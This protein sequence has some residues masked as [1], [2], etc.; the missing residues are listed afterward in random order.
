MVAGRSIRILFILLTLIA[1]VSYAQ[2]SNITYPQED[3]SK[4]EEII[5]VCKTHFDIGYTHRVDELISFYRTAMIDK[6]LAIME[7]SEELPPEQQFV[8]TTPAWVMSKVL[9]DWDG[10]TPER[11]KK[12][13]EAFKSGRFVAHSLPFTS[14]SD[15]MNPEEFA[16]GTQYSS[17]VSK[18]YE[19]PLSYDA[20]VTDVASHSNTL[21]TGLANSGKLSITFPPEMKVNIAQPVNMRGEK[22][23]D[24]MT[25]KGGK[26]SFQLGK[27]APASFILK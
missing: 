7:D 11:K 3:P 15:I 9:E 6:A 8:W 1:T 21:A 4:V 27:Y 10:Q 13:E 25:V 19:L 17:F 22:I 24:H 14:H 16:R 12:L 5:V 20:K 2:N 18:K 23:G 26:L